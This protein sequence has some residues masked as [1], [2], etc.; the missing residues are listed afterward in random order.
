MKKKDFYELSY[1][2]MV[3]ALL[4]IKLNLRLNYLDKKKILD[5]AFLFSN[6][7]KPKTLIPYIISINNKEK[8]Q[9]EYDEKILEYKWQQF[10]NSN[11]E[12]KKEVDAYYKEIE[13]AIE[14]KHRKEKINEIENIGEKENDMNLVIISGNLVRNP[15]GAVT[16]NGKSYSR[17]DLAVNE[18]FNG[19]D[20]T[21]YVKVSCWDKTA[22]FVNNYVK[23][24]EGVIIEGRL[25]TYEYTVA[26]QKR[27][28]LEVVAR[29]VERPNVS[30]K[31]KNTEETFDYSY[32]DA[33]KD[34]KEPTLPTEDDDIPF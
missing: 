20:N 30:S 11:P 13:E 18:R 7:Y 10:V 8:I 4:E 22:D 9:C 27:S 23:K 19:V 6:G 32:N 33:M 3:D 28:G 1:A 2:E 29:S 21:T 14:E 24:G 25:R 34:I 5:L 15:E 17:F 26:G 16:S 12:Y 31:P